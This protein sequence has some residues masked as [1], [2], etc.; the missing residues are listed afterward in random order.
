MTCQHVPFLGISPCFF[1]GGHHFA[2]HDRVFASLVP[3]SA[4]SSFYSRLPALLTLLPELFPP[5]TSLSLCPTLRPESPAPCF[6]AFFR[7]LACEFPF[8][9]FFFLTG[10]SRRAYLAWE[11]SAAPFG[12]QVGRLA[13]NRRFGQVSTE[14]PLQ[15]SFYPRDSRKTWLLLFASSS[16][17][18]TLEQSVQVSIKFFPSQELMV[19]PQRLASFR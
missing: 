8:G 19:L 18:M 4:F 9:L 5:E 2:A 1:F 13:P 12:P 15:K 10:R 7:R 11:T 3:R 14:L 17:M 16:T 6:F